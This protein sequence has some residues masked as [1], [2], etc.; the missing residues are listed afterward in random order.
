[1]AG[2]LNVTLSKRGVYELVGG[3]AEPAVSDI[4]RALRIGDMTVAL[5]VGGLMVAGLIYKKVINQRSSTEPV[6]QQ[7][8]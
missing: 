3:P 5:G 2:A 4:K 8:G 6:V 1:M 7:R